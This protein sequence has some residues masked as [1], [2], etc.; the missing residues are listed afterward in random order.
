MTKIKKVFTDKQVEALLVA[1][2]GG[3]LGSRMKAIIATMW[4]C[5]LRVGEVVALRTSDLNWRENKIRIR[6]GKG[7]KDDWTMMPNAL[8]PYIDGWLAHREKVEL[9]KNSPLFCV[10]SKTPGKAIYTQY[11][12]ARMKKLGEKVFGADEPC[13]PH[14][15]RRTS[16][17]RRLNQGYDLTEVA[18]M[19]RHKTTASTHHYLVLAKKEKLAEKMKDHW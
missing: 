10:L 5:G 4:I 3:A 14:M 19:L 6:N 9:P 15:L 1:A 17:T 18:S 11:V 2:G 16:A 8:R 7:A 12:W 13:H